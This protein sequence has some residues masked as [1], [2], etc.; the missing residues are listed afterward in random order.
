MAHF[1]FASSLDTQHKYNIG[2][3][4]DLNINVYYGHILSS[5]SVSYVPADKPIFYQG[6]LYQ[7]GISVLGPWAT[8]G[9]FFK[10]GRTSVNPFVSYN[11]MYRE[12]FPE[13]GVMPRGLLPGVGIRYQINEHTSVWLSLPYPIGIGGSVK[14]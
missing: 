7:G 6:V 1:I 14:L 9:P 10:F 3:T 4:H 13:I 11:P 12:L 2:N 8:V 5:L